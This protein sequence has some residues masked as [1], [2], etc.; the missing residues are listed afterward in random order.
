VGVR[1]RG[2]LIGAG[3]PTAQRTDPARP[4]PVPHRPLLVTPDAMDLW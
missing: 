2:R 3:P 4:G 1:L